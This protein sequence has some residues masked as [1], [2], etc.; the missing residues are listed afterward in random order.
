VEFPGAL[1]RF[2]LLSPLSVGADEQS[3]RSPIVLFPVQAPPASN[4]LHGELGRIVGHAHVDHGSIAGNVIS[5]V[6][7]RLARAEMRKI[8][9]QPVTWSTPDS[10]RKWP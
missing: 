9:Q 6:R 10:T 4:A 1:W 3:F 8:M 7:N 2:Q 5:S